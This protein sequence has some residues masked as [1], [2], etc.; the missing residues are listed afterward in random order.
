MPTKTKIAVKHVKKPVIVSGAKGITAAGRRKIQALLERASRD[1]EL[2]EALLSN[3]KAAAKK[4]GTTF[5]LTSAE[6]T[7][8]FSLR[9]VALEEIG[10]DVR[11]I[12]SWL[13]DNGNFASS[14]D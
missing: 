3:P 10:V 13:R 8:L 1:I 11:G 6:A 4:I 12:R 2:R 14:E 5:G 7:V 9:R